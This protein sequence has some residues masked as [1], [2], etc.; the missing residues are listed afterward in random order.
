MTNVPESIIARIAKLLGL[1]KSDNIN[2]AAV[3][4]TQAL[5]DE[6]RFDLYENALILI[7]RRVP[8]G[9]R[10]GRWLKFALLG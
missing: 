9:G 1:A 2:E 6:Q 10:L 4:A 3:A 7:A 5:T 8:C